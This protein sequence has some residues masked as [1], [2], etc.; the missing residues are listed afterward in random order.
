MLTSAA[1]SPASLGTISRMSLVEHG[2]EEIWYS[3]QFQHVLERLFSP[4][5][6]ERKLPCVAC[7]YFRVA[8]YPCPLAAL[9]G[10]W[11]VNY[12]CLDAMTRMAERRGHRA[13]WEGLLSG[14][15]SFGHV[16]R[17][18]E[19]GIQDEVTSSTNR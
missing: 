1:C 7:K 10:S 13:P 17:A 18:Q 5:Q 11:S 8:C 2:F 14:Q 12:R 9:D 19:E 15:D 4:E 16:S 3:R 6:D